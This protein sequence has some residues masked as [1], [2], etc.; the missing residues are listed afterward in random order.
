MSNKFVGTW[1]LVISHNRHRIMKNFTR[2][3]LALFAV[4]VSSQFLQA[5]S[6]ADVAKAQ[7]VINKINK[8]VEKYREMTI[9]L[10]APKSLEGGQ[11]KFMV[12]FTDDRDLTAWASKA[13]EAQAGAA[14]G[15]KAGSAVGK[16]L[17]AKVPLGGLMGASAKKKGKKV[18]TA[19]ALGGMPFIKETTDQSLNNV[20]DYIVFLHVVHGAN[21]N[22][23]S[24]LASAMALHPEMEGRID[25]AIKNA[26]KKA[27]KRK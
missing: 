26:Y 13:L 10:E 6:M 20:D 1:D 18:G 16:A 11:G 24:G 12:P 2:L 15:E 25:F 23:Q 4:V 21:P 5:A 14:V 22:Y 17:G 27:A 7:V 8:V 3:V 19:V 9:D